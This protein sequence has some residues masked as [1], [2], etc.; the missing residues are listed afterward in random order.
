LQRRDLGEVIVDTANRLQGREFD[1]VVVWHPLA[2]RRDASAFHLDAGRAAVL[3][4]R[5]R[6]ACVVV[7]RAGAA[8][9][10]E[11]HAPPSEYELGVTRQVEFDGWEAHARLL[12][13]LETVKI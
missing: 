6:H 5:H 13:H 2:G 10:L 12:E 3:T 4:T 11:D 1:I 7:G 8:Q 9:V